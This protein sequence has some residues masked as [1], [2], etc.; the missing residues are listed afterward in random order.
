VSI[1]CFSH[2][3]LALVLDSLTSARNFL[4]AYSGGMDSHV[5]LHAMSMLARERRIAV[6]AIH[7]H[8]G[9]HPDADAWTE[10]CAGVC[11]V[12]D[13]PLDILRVNAAAASGESP[14]AAARDARYNALAEFLS[15]GHVLLTAHHMDDQTETFLLQLIRGSGL[16]GLSSMPAMQPLGKGM[17]AR[18]LLHYSRDDLAQYA[19]QKDLGWIE[20]SSNSDVSFDRNYLRHHV[21]SR[22]LVR[23]PGAR[24]TIARA[25][26]LAAET[27]GLAE[28]LARQDLVRVREAAGNSLDL[29]V[30]RMLP[31]ERCRNLLRIWVREAG[32]SVPSAAKIERVARD[33][34]P[35]APD[36]NPLVSWD[37]AEIRRYRNRLYLMPPLPVVGAMDRIPWRAETIDLPLGQLCNPV[38]RG[39]G[40][41]IAKLEAGA[42]E[43]RFRA[44]GES[45]RPSAGRHKRRVKK[46]MQEQGIPPWLRELVPMIYV[47][48]RLAAVVGICLDR[49]WAA[50]GSEPGRLPV[51]QL[52]ESLSGVVPVVTDHE[53]WE[54]VQ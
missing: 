40:L 31:A 2:R 42:V 46:L 22:I 12:L 14:E 6:S 20:D 3:E 34:L 49:E 5:L 50:C 47:N 53:P 45:I 10:H 38:V 43:I 36:R 54:T 25:A 51:W 39:R 35:A 7:I 1:S 30:L 19:N 15:S 9:L 13:I 16:R 8:H 27:V 21:M 33:V 41:S 24:K 17:M 28:T 18:P 44:G 48:G 26:T 4:V 11:K 32:Y 37:G 23:W 52:P 29:S